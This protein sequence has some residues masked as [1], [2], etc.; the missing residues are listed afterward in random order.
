MKCYFQGS[1]RLLLACSLAAALMTG[2]CGTSDQPLP[3]DIQQT[4][5]MPPPPP[6]PKVA[7]GRQADSG[8]VYSVVPEMPSFPE[9]EDSLMHYLSSHIHYPAAARENGIMGTVVV[10]FDVDADGNIS[11]VHTLGRPKG[12]GLEGEAVRVVSSMPPWKPG[13]KDGKAVNVQYA[14]P[15]RFVLQ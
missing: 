10:Q 3:S 11:G 2:G 7:Q 6:P 5:H 15:I 8:Q 12:G 14:L 9:G 4:Q 1:H 13:F